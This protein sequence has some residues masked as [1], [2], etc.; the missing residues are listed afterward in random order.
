MSEPNLIYS[1]WPVIKTEK[2]KV[3]ES[4]TIAGE[5]RVIETDL[6]LSWLLDVGVRAGYTHNGIPFN[7][8][9]AFCG[10]YGAEY[11][12]RST[13]EEC[14]RLCRQ[15]AIKA[16]ST[17]TLEA[18]GTLSAIPC[19]P[20]EG[21]EY[22]GKPYADLRYLRLAGH[23]FESPRVLQQREIAVI[24]VW[25]SKWDAATIAAAKDAFLARIEQA[26]VEV[27]PDA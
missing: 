15:F 2:V 7:D 27:L 18:F 11:A 14:R 21:H 10:G 22:G 17:L 13:L 9:P 25:S 4:V 26:K 20:A 16:D 1:R 3:A 23:T 19:R 8:G 6:E 24:Q 12:L 5:R